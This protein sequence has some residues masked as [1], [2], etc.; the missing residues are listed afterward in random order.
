MANGKREVKR[1]LLFN[2]YMS[3]LDSGFVRQTVGYADND[4]FP[5]TSLVPKKHGKLLVL[6]YVFS[7]VT[8]R[9][10]DF[11]YQARIPLLA[12]PLRKNP[13]VCPDKHSTLERH[14]PSP[15]GIKL[16]FGS[17]EGMARTSRCLVSPKSP[18][19][20]HSHRPVNRIPSS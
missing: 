5:I 15:L 18:S 17:R 3:S 7:D 9:I 8:T 16:I 13:P 10:R 11:F 19:P 20:E 2:C 6:I 4:F 12:V 14:L 1:G